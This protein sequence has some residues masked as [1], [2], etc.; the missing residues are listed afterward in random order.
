MTISDTLS[1]IKLLE[2]LPLVL[3]TK[4]IASKQG[5]TNYLD[6]GSINTSRLLTIVRTK[7]TYRRIP[8]TRPGYIE[9]IVI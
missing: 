2:D 4:A 6:S 3:S 8:I 7:G 9:S 5:S 1:T